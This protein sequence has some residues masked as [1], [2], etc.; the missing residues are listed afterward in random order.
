MKQQVGL[1]NWSKVVV[2]IHRKSKLIH[3]KLKLKQIPEMTKIR[4]ANVMM[5]LK[6]ND[7]TRLALGMI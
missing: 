1:S 4:S 5:S 3:R 7:I 6:G 2:S